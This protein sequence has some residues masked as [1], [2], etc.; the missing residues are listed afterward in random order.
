MTPADIIAQGGNLFDAEDF[1]RSV[2][3][4]IAIRGIKQSDCARDTGISRATISRICSGRKAPDVEN[5]LRLQNWMLNTA[6]V[7][8]LTDG[9]V[10]E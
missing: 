9:G 1:A 3:M 7:R 5:Y 8:S 6:A 4:Q 2:R 10:G